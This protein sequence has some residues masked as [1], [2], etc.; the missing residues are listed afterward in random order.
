[1]QEMNTGIKKYLGKDVSTEAKYEPYFSGNGRYFFGYKTNK[2]YGKNG[3][4][5]SGIHLLHKGVKIII[6]ENNQWRDKH[7]Q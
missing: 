4:A 7:G 2:H 3:N 5:K 1:M 6:G